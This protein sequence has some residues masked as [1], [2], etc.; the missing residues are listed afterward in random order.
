ME[1]RQNWTFLSNHAHVVIALAKDATLRVRDLAEQVGI[2]ERA[3]TQIVSDLEAAGVLAKE[4]TGRRNMYHIDETVPLR[5]PVESHRTVGDIL[6]L[7]EPR[8]RPL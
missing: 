3:V 8:D 2:T 1:R 5:H 7:A 4:R 6:R